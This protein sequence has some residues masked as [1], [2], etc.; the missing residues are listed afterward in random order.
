MKTALHFGTRTRWSSAAPAHAAMSPPTTAHRTVP[1]FQLRHRSLIL[2]T[3]APH[4][5]W[6]VAML[7]AIAAVREQSAN[8]ARITH[9]QAARESAISSR[10]EHD[11]RAN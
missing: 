5:V 4:D 2:L 11:A 1:P 7:P 6:G 8:S 10:I 9:A 3:H